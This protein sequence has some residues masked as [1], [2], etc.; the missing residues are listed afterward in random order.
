M[1]R[2]IIFIV[3]ILGSWSIY[4]QCTTREDGTI[5]SKWIKLG[6][7]DKL[8]VSKLEHSTIFLFQF[9]YFDVFTVDENDGLTIEL[10]NGEKLECL[11]TS[12]SIANYTTS[13]PWYAIFSSYLSNEYL[14]KL[15]E[16]DIVK[17]T[18]HI[19]G[20]IRPIKMTKKRKANIKEILTCVQ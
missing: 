3:L 11:A 15:L 12:T 10:S 9:H 14:T 17:A 2:Y 5:E 4:G 6:I 1:K 8:K 20:I 16:Y 7:N 18:F 19:E 13:G